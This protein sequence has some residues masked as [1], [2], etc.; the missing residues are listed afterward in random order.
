MIDVLENMS[1][2]SLA[3]QL[4]KKY[5]LHLQHHRILAPFCTRGSS[6]DH[7]G[8][9]LILSRKVSRVVSLFRTANTREDLNEKCGT[10]LF[11]IHFVSNV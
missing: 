5:D 3:S 6:A 8:L 9:V 1:E 7:R 10:S 4:R 11:M 2:K